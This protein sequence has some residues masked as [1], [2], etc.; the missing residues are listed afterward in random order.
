MK[1]YNLNIDT[2]K[3][4]N[5]VV[6]MQ[7]GATGLL[8]LNITN[9][10][11]TIHNLTTKVYDGGVEVPSTELLSVETSSLQSFTSETSFITFTLPR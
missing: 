8:N 1:I 7:Q 6:Q 5:Q 3:P 11:N 9:D 10:G 2:S 4:T